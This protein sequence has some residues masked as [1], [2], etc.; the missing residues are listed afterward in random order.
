MTERLLRGRVL[1]FR[2]E[3]AGPGDLQAL[4]WHED[5]AVHLR[6]GHIVAMGDFDTLAAA[7]PT[8]PTTADNRTE[9]RQRRMS[10][11]CSAARSMYTSRHASHR[12]R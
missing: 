4:H 7:A 8:V 12:A 6:D 11:G 1:S 5:G 3:P 9:G 10:V 2:R